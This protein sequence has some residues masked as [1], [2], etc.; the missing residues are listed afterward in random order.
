[1][2]E[3]GDKAAE[4]RRLLCRGLRRFGRFRGGN[5]NG[6][7]GLPPRT[8]AFGGP[9]PRAR[10]NKINLFGFDMIMLLGAGAARQPRL[11]QALLADGGVPVREQFA[12]L[13]AVLRSKRRRS[14]DAFD[15]HTREA[16]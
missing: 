13:R 11:G 1:M 7:G 14:A 16:G 2:C 3:G 15:F 10:R 8:S 12:Y 4:Q 6:P 9:P 5:G